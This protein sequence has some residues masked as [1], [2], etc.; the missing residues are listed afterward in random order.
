MSQANELTVVV[1]DTKQEER[2]ELGARKQGRRDFVEFVGGGYDQ[3]VLTWT[4]K[5]I[6]TSRELVVEEQ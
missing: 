1:S 6:R 2:V 5:W 4:Q 3:A